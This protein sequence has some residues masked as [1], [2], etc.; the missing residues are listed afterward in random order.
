MSIVSFPYEFQQGWGVF[1]GLGILAKAIFP[2]GF[3]DMPPR[4]LRMA[5]AFLTFGF[6]I[7]PRGLWMLAKAFLLI[8][9]GCVSR[10][11]L[12][13]ARSSFPLGFRHAPIGV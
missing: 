5:K 7:M 13:E 9:L 6:G 3:Q 1:R 12:K 8:K 2:F 11:N 4:L 10:G